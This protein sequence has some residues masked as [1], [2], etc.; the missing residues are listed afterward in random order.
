[1]RIM[2]YAPGIGLGHVRRCHNIAQEVLQ[3]DP[4]SSIIIVT[5]AQAAHNYASI[6]GVDYLKLPSIT[7]IRRVVWIPDSIGMETNEL[8]A[9]RSDIMLAAFRSFAPDAVVVDHRPVGVYGE[10][11]PLLTEAAERVPR[12]RLYLGLRDILDDPD[13]MWGLWDS[14]DARDFMS[15]YD[16][17]IIYGQPDFYDLASAMALE[18]AV[19]DIV[20][21]GYVAPPANGVQAASPRRPFVLMTGGAGM[22]AFPVA[23]AFVGALPK[24]LSGADVDADIV[25]GPRMPREKQDELR[26]ALPPERV[27]LDTS[28]EDATRLIRGASVIV[29]M[30]G[31]NTS[32]EALRWGRKALVVPRFGPSNEQ[33]MRSRMLEERNLIRVIE[34][35]ALSAQAIAEGVLELLQ[36]DA[37]PDIEAMPRLDGAARVAELLTNGHAKNT[38]RVPR[39]L[40]LAS[41]EEG[42]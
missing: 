4:D 9:L 38:S 27:R 15:L 25:T 3:R 17:A 21:S 22:D 13:V 28:V 31:Y 33:R 20:W 11:K 35:E 40:A 32:I 19:Q 37:M 41:A 5:D 29:T 6:K 7:K 16:A 1:M 18:G 30:G 10:L 26:A 2:M 42:V 39:N 8:V 24:I 14:M 12:T 23:E 36:D 34:P